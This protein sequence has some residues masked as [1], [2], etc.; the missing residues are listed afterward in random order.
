MKIGSRQ[1]F[2]G[3][4]ESPEIVIDDHMIKRVN[5]KKVLGI[6]VDD[7]LKWNKHHDFQ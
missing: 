6:I 3:F 7:Q 2:G 1:R 4:G 5:D